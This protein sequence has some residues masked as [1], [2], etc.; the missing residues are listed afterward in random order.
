MEIE[1]ASPEKSMTQPALVLI[2]LL[3]AAMIGGVVGALLG[4][5]VAGLFG[6]EDLA[7][8]GEGEAQVLTLMERNGLR[9]YNFV[10]HL[11]FFTISSLAVAQVVARRSIWSFLQLD[12]FVTRQ[13]AGLVLVLTLTAF[14][15]MQVV[16][17]LNQQIPLPT[18]MAN[19]EQQQGW[20]VQEV[21]RMEYGYEF[22]LALLVAAITPAIGEELLFRGVL[23]TQLERWWKNPHGAVWVAAFIFSAIHMQFA[24][25][26]PR[27]LLGAYLGYLLIWTESLWVPILAHFLF[28]GIQ[29]TAVAFAELPVEASEQEIEISAVIWWAIPAAMVFAWGLRQL[30]RADHKDEQPNDPTDLVA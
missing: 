19:M 16:F 21:L 24:G 13:Q 5:S 12:R 6:L 11:F 8:L 23:Q 26:F 22:W 10:A 15:L 17:W 28:N 18:W 3:L 9:W 4:Q 27:F 7:A 20:L 1:S 2:Y 30:F 14:P 25:F 29:I